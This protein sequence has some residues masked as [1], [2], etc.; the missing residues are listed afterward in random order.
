MSS[1]GRERRRAPLSAPAA[2]LRRV[3][4]P[5]VRLHGRYQAL[6]TF[7]SSVLPGPPFK[8][9]PVTPAVKLSVK[10]V[11]KLLDD[12]RDTIIASLQLTDS[13]L[14]VICLQAA[15]MASRGPSRHLRVL[16]WNTSLLRQRHAELKQCLLQDEYGVLALEEVYATSGTTSCTVS[17]CSD[18]PCL[19]DGHSQNAARYAVYVRTSIPHTVRVENLTNSPLECCAVRVRLGSWDTNVDSFLLLPAR[20]GR[21]FLFD[22]AVVLGAEPLQTPSFEQASR[23]RAPGSLPLSQVCST[24]NWNTFRR[25]SASAA[26]G[27]FMQN[28]ADSTQAPTVASRTQ[29]GHP[30]SDLKQQHLSGRRNGRPSGGWT[31]SV[32]ATKTH[33]GSRAEQDSNAWRLLRTLQR[34]PAIR[35]P[36]LS[37]AISL[38]LRE[39]AQA[40]LLAIQFAVRPP[41]PTMEARLSEGPLCIPRIHYRVF[42]IERVAALCDEPFPPHELAAFLNRSNTGS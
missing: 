9:S 42:T 18:V 6:F 28:V 13:P 38:G 40:D 41:G 33:D 32:D 16:Q 19:V 21:D 2:C 5:R 7:A 20:L 17:G 14:K 24:V 31:L 36:I 11:P 34:G 39:L 30:V 3:P 35:H 23:S 1:S 29:P 27:D 15:I 26:E 22:A 10:P 37:V 8:A 4:S 25:L 12:P